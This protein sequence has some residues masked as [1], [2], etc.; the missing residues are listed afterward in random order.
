MND[1]VVVFNSRHN[2]TLLNGNRNDAT[3]NFDWSKLKEAKYEVSMSCNMGSLVWNGDKIAQV[4]THFGNTPL[5]Y[6]TLENTASANTEFMGYLFPSTIQTA[7]AQA[8][9]LSAKESD[10]PHFHLGGRPTE[11]KPRITFRD[12]T[13]GL[14]TDSASAEI[15]HYI[16][17]IRLTEVRSEENRKDRY[18]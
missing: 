2:A 6:K 5:V 12:G 14:L 3:Y 17:T 7:T 13:G 16:L 18:A 10:N 1:I 11:Q 15:P 4:F 8:T 9:I